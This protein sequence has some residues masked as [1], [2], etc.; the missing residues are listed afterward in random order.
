M[1]RTH[2]FSV[3]FGLLVLACAA[4]QAQDMTPALKDLVAA[5][6]KEAAL[7]LSWSTSSYDG[8]QGAARFQTAMNKMFGSS[9][10]INFVPGPDMARVGNQLATEF[11]ANQ[12]AHV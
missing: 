12:K 7:T 11:S 5:A 8:V 9:V 10:R 4:A 3:G 1:K 6:N 2:T